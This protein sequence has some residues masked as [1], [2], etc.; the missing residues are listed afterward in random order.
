MAITLRSVSTFFK[1]FWRAFDLVMHLSL[2]AALATRAVT[3]YYKFEDPI[4][5]YDSPKVILS[6]ASTG[7]NTI[8]PSILF[9]PTA[10]FSNSLSLCLSESLSVSLSL[11]LSVSLSLCLSVSLSLCLSVSLSLSK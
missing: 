6:E 1:K 8:I 2:S 5:N 7:F 11:C 10:S 9:S 4:R 3:V